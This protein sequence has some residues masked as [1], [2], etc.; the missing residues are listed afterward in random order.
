MAKDNSNGL[1]VTPHIGDGAVL[2]AFDLDK[3]KVANLAGFSVECTTPEGRGTFPT[4]KYFL[5][6]ALSFENKITS[7]KKL[8]SVDYKGS[9]KAPFQ[10]FHWIHFPSAGEGQYRYTVYASYFKHNGDLELGPKVNCSVNLMYRSHTSSLE[11]GFTRGYISS[12]AYVQRF[13]NEPISPK[14][15][16]IDFDTSGYQ[17]KYQWL[18]AHARMMIFDFLKECLKDTAIHAD[19]FSFDFDEPDIVRNLCKMGKRVRVFQDDSKLH[20]SANSIEPKAMDTLRKAGVLVKTGHFHRF[21]H[22]KVI[23]QKKNN[24]AIKVLTGSANFS[25]RGLYVQANSVIIFDDPASA[26]LYE[27]AFEQAF[28]DQSGFSSSIIASKW[29]DLEIKHNDGGGT[30][31]K[32]K[33]KNLH[34]SFAPHK[35]AFSLEKVS[36]AIEDAKSSVFFA[37]MAP[38]GGGTV[39]PDLEKL[40]DKK[41][42]LSLGIIQMQG[43]LKLFRPGIGSAVTSFGFLH[44]QV[45]EPF[46]EEWSGGPGQV[47]HHKFVVCDFDKESPVVFCGSSNLADG[48]E[49]SNGD[50][51]IAIYDRSIA[52]CYAVEAI[53]LF[54]HYRFRNLHENSTSNNPLLLDSTDKWTKPYYDL[55]DIKSRERLILSLKASQ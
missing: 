24:R 31:L 46:R 47:I 51:L 54:D 25:L 17:K 9:D 36:S 8:T 55:K 39:M 35:T 33:G 50:N 52:T 5:T 34:L 42:L 11:L 7:D 45:Q 18:G 10:L 40:G 15:K 27:Q 44:S 32:S 53:R 20:T 26:E 3:D 12:Q 49:K 38:E 29:F 21:A 6:N 2:L 30:N 48:G 4:N 14:P 22:D 16:T 43:Q 19:I 1:T 28:T 41:Q 23:I 13:K 37:V